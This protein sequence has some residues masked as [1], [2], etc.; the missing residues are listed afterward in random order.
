MSKKKDRAWFVCPTWGELVTRH[1]AGDA[2]AAR[3]LKTRPQVLARLRAGAPVA[4]ATLLK[5]LRRLTAQHGLGV[6]AHRLVV[7]TRTR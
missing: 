1:Y 5:L 6:P 4:K 2:E 3:A 7:D